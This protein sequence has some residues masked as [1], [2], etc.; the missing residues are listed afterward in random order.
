MKKGWQPKT[1]GDVA[2]VGAGNSDPQGGE[3]LLCVRGSTGVVSIA[4]P[5]LAGENGSS[6]V[7]TVVEW[8][9]APSL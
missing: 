5:E 8:C 3:L 4:S 6:L 1:L 7:D 9:Y 2:V